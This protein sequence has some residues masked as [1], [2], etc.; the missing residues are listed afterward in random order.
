MYEDTKPNIIDRTAF[1]AVKFDH[2]V[3]N[4]SWLRWFQIMACAFVFA[5]AATASGCATYNSTLPFAVAETVEQRAFA[6]YGTFVITEERAV[7]VVR[8]SKIPKTLRRRVQTADR[9]AKPMADKLRQSA[10]FLVKLRQQFKSGKLDGKVLSAATTSVE[11][12]LVKFK[13]VMTEMTK[14]LEGL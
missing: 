14:S 1:A 2:T 7:A 3:S 5:F 13:P 9:I 4:L 8:N 11:H 12:D 10:V 6:A